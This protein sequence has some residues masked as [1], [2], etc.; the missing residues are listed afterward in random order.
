MAGSEVGDI[1]GNLHRSLTGCPDICIGTDIFH[2]PKEQLGLTK[3]FF[4]PVT[5]TSVSMIPFH[6]CS[7]ERVHGIMLE[8]NRDLYRND[9]DTVRQNIRGWLREIDNKY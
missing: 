4:S 6:Y 5:I 3:D 1:D 2:T 7:D 8:L 9:F